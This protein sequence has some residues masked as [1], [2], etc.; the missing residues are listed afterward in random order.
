MKAETLFPAASAMPLPYEV[1]SIGIYQ[2]QCEMLREQGYPGAQVLVSVEGCGILE[3]EGH[4][5]SL[6]E[7]DIIFLPADTKHHYYPESL[8]QAWRLDWI[9]FSGGCLEGTLERLNLLEAKVLFGSD[10]ERVGRILRQIL[11]DLKMDRICGQERASVHI[12]ELLMEIYRLDKEMN[13]AQYK[14]TNRLVPVLDYIDEHITEAMTLEELAQVL[15]I[16]PQHLC[17]TFRE[18][19]AMRPFEYVTK[20]RI[21]L[22]KKYLAD[23]SIKIASV[24]KLVGIRD[25]SYYCYNFKRIEGITPNEFRNLNF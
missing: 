2:E 9:S 10:T 17:R 8:H 1:I 13:V 15:H 22:S 6:G 18:C 7:G 25:V 11:S 19:F 14:M 16:T 20:R 3:T 5:F 24:G 23:R 4:R 21:Q 12:Y